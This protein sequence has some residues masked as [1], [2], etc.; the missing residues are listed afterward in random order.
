[1]TALE[2]GRC[3]GG[4]AEMREDLGDHGRMFD[5]GDEF[6]AITRQVLFAVGRVTEQDD[7]KDGMTWLKSKVPGDWDQRLIATVPLLGYLG[8]YR[9]LEAA[10][11]TLRLD[12]A[13]VHDGRMLGALCLDRER[14]LQ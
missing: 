10:C 7:V 4:Q 5:G 2:I 3:P 13:H 6:A 12:R 1:M 9:S 14:H 11:I 8:R